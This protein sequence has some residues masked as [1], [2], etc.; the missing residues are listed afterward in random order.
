MLSATEEAK[1]KTPLP[2]SERADHPGREISMQANNCQ[3]INDIK[4]VYTKFHST[5]K[6][7]L[8]LLRKTRMASL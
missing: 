8:T 7:T 1:I 2:N 3:K 5:K 4:Q 6:E